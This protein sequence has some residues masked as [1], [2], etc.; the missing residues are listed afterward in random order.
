MYK[1]GDK[2]I[3]KYSDGYDIREG[4]IYTAL[5]DETAGIMPGKENR[6]ITFIDDSGKK[7]GAHARRFKPLQE[8]TK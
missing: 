4:A 7:C 2:M 1:K 6:L 8:Q 5:E 3:C